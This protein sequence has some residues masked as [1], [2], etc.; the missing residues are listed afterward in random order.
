[1]QRYPDTNVTVEDFLRSAWKKVIDTSDRDGYASMWTSLSR[2]AQ[3]AIQDGDLTE[4]KILLLLADA[5]SMML[6]PESPNE[7]FK[8]FMVIGNARSSLPE[9]FQ[10]VDVTFFGQIAQEI[11]DP[12]LRGRLADL[13]WLLRIPKDPKYAL[14]AID[15]YRTIPLEAEAWLRDGRECW[16][17]AIKLS[18][19]L[20]S[21]AGERL[22]DLEQDIITAFETATK[23]D[24]FF[25]LW[26]S[27][28][29]ESNTLGGENSTRVANKLLL[30]AQSFDR[31]ERF[32][33]ARLFFNSSASWF[34]RARNF[35]KSTEATISAAETWVKEA[36]QRLSSTLPSNAVAASFYENAIQTFRSIPRKERALSGVQERIDEVHLLMKEAGEKALNEMGRIRSDSIDITAIVE[37]SRNAVRGK[38]TIAAIAAL[39]NIFSGTRVVQL[40]KRSKEMINAYPL[41]RL[42]SSS[43]L[44]SDGRVIAKRPGVRPG[45]MDSHENQI[46]VW[47]EMVKLYGWDLGVIV[48][49]FILPALNVVILEHRLRERDFVVFAG[50]S[51]IVPVGRERLF[52]KAL[53][54]GFERDFA[55]AL[56]LLIPQI[57]NMV[58]WHLK[59]AGFKTTNLDSEGIENEN[60]LSTLVDLPATAEVFGEDLAFELKAL[61][62]DPLGPNLRN[63]LAHGLLSD[64]ACNS[65]FSIYAWWL[66]LRIVFNAFWNTKRNSGT[67]KEDVGAEEDEPQ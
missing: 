32:H 66:C 46:I 38:D 15:A 67:R 34:K 26:L 30:F 50:E 51:P 57:E 25:L 4:G 18:L 58:R 39:A 42:F 48:Q 61:F 22:K 62:C 55:G 60:G 41:Q 35:E 17:R 1:M 33:P 8:P 37:S 10:E 28:L 64:D 52:G 2:A 53:Y 63:E 12:W 23:D 40:R 56:H 43:H 21:G 49:A 5:C 59:V 6:S 65:P 19:T 14:M 7:P 13:I 27:E 45:D 31:E 54:L 11:D 24:G 44:A 9:D 29:L 36:A 3:I 20:G 16:Q 47:S